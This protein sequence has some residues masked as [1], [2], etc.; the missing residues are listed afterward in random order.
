MRSSANPHRW[1]GG[2]AKTEDYQD[3]KVQDGGVDGS[4]EDKKE[5]DDNGGEDDGFTA[6][7]NLH[8]EDYE[9]QPPPREDKRD[10]SYDP[11]LP[12]YPAAGD[13][14]QVK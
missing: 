5:G 7:L 11:S 1:Y 12:H 13:E 3:D 14:D 2:S 4:Y 6:S 10:T 8:S 9:P